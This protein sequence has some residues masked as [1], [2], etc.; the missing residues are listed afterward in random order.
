MKKQ[1]N[2]YDRVHE[3]SQF[4]SSNKQ[5]YAFINSEGNGITTFLLNKLYQKHY[6]FIKEY[7]NDAIICNN[8][9]TTGFFIDTRDEN[10]RQ[11]K[12]NLIEANCY[13]SFIKEIPL[14]CCLAD[15]IETKINQQIELCEENRISV[16]KLIYDY[17]SL[18]HKD[19]F[20]IIID[21][22]DDV[23]APFLRKLIRLVEH[24][25]VKIIFTFTAPAIP[26]HYQEILSSDLCEIINFSKPIYKNATMI[27]RNLNYDENYYDETMYEESSCIKDFIKKYATAYHLLLLGT[28]LQPYS[29]TKNL[30]RLINICLPI[31]T[32]SNFLRNLSK[33]FTQSML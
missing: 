18:P 2:C 29:N 15:F 28:E 16:L 3:T 21:K 26:A 33:I 17:L 10:A 8:D 19:T 31:D 6:L 11:N 12:K 27:F 20:Y 7:N 24:P 25:N 32:T 22:A 13:L 14:G 1:V 30:L 9:D 4:I 23:T 5:C